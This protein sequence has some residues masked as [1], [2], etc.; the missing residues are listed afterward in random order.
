M[1]LNGLEATELCDAYQSALGEGGGWFVQRLPKKKQ[2]AEA[3]YFLGS[4]LNIVVET[5]WG[6]LNEELEDLERCKKQSV[7]I[8]SNHLSTALYSIGGGR[9]FLST[10]QKGRPDCYKVKILSTAF[11]V[12]TTC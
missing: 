10:Y 6:S 3:H 7:V 4:C 9:C 1:S 8:R 5:R 2:K 12:S 11:R